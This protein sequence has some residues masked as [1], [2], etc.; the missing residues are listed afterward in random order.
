MPTNSFQQFLKELIMVYICITFCG[1]SISLSKVMT[2]G[3]ILHSPPKKEP[4][5]AQPKMVYEGT[6]QAGL[7]VDIPVYS[8]VSTRCSKSPSWTFFYKKSAPNG[9]ICGFCEISFKGSIH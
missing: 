3:V 2:R 5:K 4:Q 9:R 6:C 7:F 8:T 1:C